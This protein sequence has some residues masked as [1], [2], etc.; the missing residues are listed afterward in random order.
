MFLTDL[1]FNN[2]YLYAISFSAIYL[3]LAFN[4]SNAVCMHLSIG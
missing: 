3:P 4:I 2:N 1:I